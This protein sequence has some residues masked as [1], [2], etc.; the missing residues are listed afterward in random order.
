MGVPTKNDHFGVEIGGTPSFGNLQMVGPK[1]K[2]HRLPVPSIVRCQR[3]VSFREDMATETRPFAPP[4]RKFHG[5][6]SFIASGMV[7]VDA[8][9][10]MQTHHLMFRS[11]W[12]L[13]GAQGHTAKTC[14]D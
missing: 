3:T 1:K 11:L 7:A 10:I 6:Q 4:K 2:G 12:H 13:V 9:E 8:S 5:L 14:N